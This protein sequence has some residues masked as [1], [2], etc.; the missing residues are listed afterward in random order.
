MTVQRTYMALAV[1]VVG[2]GVNRRAVVPDRARPRRPMPADLYVG[3]PLVH[4]VQ[5]IEDRVGLGLVEPVDA[6][7]HSLIDPERL[8]SRDGVRADE[9]MGP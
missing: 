7:R 5:V 8:P 6:H 1:I 3:G 9:R 2:H 4:V